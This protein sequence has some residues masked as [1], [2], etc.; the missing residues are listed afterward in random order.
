MKAIFLNGSQGMINRVFTETSRD[1]INKVAPLL[2]E[3]VKA[4]ELKDR[5]GEFADVEFIFSTWG[6][7]N[8]KPE[9][10]TEHFPKLRAVFY[11]AGTVQSFAKN[12]HGHGAKVF[13]AWA[14][15]AVPVAEYIVA[16]II[17]A[18]TGFYQ[19]CKF[20][21][22]GRWHDGKKISDG[23]PHNYGIKVGLIG[24]GMIGSRVAN[25]L[26]NY[27][28]EVLAYDPY[29]SA[30]K[31]ADLGVKSVSL[32]EI[33]SE[34]QTISNHLPNNAE[35]KGMLKY[36]HFS[37]MKSNGVF[38]NTGRGAQVIEADL[39]RAMR[40]EQ[41]RT[42]VL[43]VTNPE[44]PHPYSELY[45]VPNI[46]LTPHIAGS[47]GNEVARMG[48]YVTEDFLAFIEGKETKYE[49]TPEMLETM[50]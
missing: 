45:T 30:E 6:M 36:E 33:F 34:C 49:V 16:Q 43:D 5:K 10:L 39:I 44:P 50:A 14:A 19:S 35:T 22:A 25:M 21:T 47:M 2:L 26:K 3:T 7:P 41:A 11:G 28:L 37:L 13:S 48:D 20:T 4:D 17:L 8:L 1:K 9:E 15:N 38:I 32:E 40:E 24:C 31:A 27:D 18:N 46:F 42:A 23:M 29:M 12:I